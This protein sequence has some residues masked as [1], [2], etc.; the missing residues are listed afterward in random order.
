MPKILVVDDDVPLTHELQTFFEFNNFI[1]TSVHDGDEAN[2]HLK[3]Y[4]YDLIILDWHL[5]GE[6]GIDVCR[7]FR[8]RGGQTPVIMLTG[9]TDL[10][11]RITGLDCGAD[12]YLTKPFHLGE[13]HSRVKALLRRSRELVPETIEAGDLTVDL[14]TRRVV[15]AGKQV[16]LS[17]REFELLAFLVKNQDQVFSAEVLLNRVW[18]SESEATIEVVRVT[19]KRVRSKLDPESKILKNL[20]GSGYM[21]TL[22]NKA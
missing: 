20:Y 17:A 1:V 3:S 5:P 12:D 6:S 9:K 19:I 4:P 22:T 13:L 2:T 21:L 10:E 14:S 7:N 15:L 8:S 18:P 11:N 16:T